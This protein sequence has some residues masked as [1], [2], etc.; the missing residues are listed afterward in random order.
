MWWWSQLSILQVQCAIFQ[1]FE[2]ETVTSSGFIL[3]CG[4]FLAPCWVCQWA[5]VACAMKTRYLFL[6]C[7]FTWRREQ[8][9]H[10]TRLSWKYG[11]ARWQQNASK[12]LNLWKFLYNYKSPL[13]VKNWITC[14]VWQIFTFNHVLIWEV[15]WALTNIKVINHA[16]YNTPDLQV[17]LRKL[18]IMRYAAQSVTHHF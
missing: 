14:L 1:E 11:R 2:K 16:K 17:S 12:T 10:T 5:T 8:S 15:F 13:G 18:V 6:L 7:W 4:V 9:P 3:D